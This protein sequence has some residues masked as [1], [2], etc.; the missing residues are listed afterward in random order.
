MTSQRDN[1]YDNAFV[2][3]NELKK[4][5]QHRFEKVM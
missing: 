2:G 4:L 5:L 3:V 1:I